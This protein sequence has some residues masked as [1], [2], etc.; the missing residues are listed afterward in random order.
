MVSY[1]QKM[2]FKEVKPMETVNKLKGILMKLGIETEEEWI[3]ESSINTYTVRITIKGTNIGANGKG[4]SKEFSLASGYAEFFERFQ[5]NMLGTSIFVKSKLESFAGYLDGKYMTAEE[6]VKE[7]SGF[8]KMYFD[9]RNMTNAAFE[10]K[11]KTFKSVQISETVL[12]GKENSYISLPFYNARSRKVE[13]LPKSAYSLYYGSNGMSAGNTPEEAMV[14]GLSEIIERYIQKR[15]FIEKPTLPDI[16]EEYV[17]K[18][19]YIY[20]M[21]MKLKDNEKYKFMLKD[22]S[23]GG[24]YPVA[25]LII[26]EKNTG[27]YGIKLGCHSDYGIAMER[28]FTEATQGQDIFE[29]TGRSTIDFFNNNVENEDNICNSYKVGLGQFPYQ[30]FGETPS[31]EFTPVKDV[32]NMTN[33]EI[34]NNWI[35]ELIDDGYDVYIRDVSYLGFP[36]FHII[37]PGMS[38]MQIANDTRFRAYNT[39]QYAAGLI[40]NV[41]KITKENTKYIIG[42]MGYFLKAMLENTM[43]IYYMHLEDVNL[44]CD[45]FYAGCLYMMSMC[46]VM[47]E[48]YLNAFKKMELVEKRA[49]LNKIDKNRLKYFTAM[50]HYFSAMYTM[51]D[52]KKAIKYMNVFF[53]SE[54]VEKL[55]ELFINPDLVIIKQ[56]P[57]REKLNALMDN[58]GYMRFEYSINKYLEVQKKKRIEQASLAKIIK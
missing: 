11:V 47:N 30:L 25:A 2:H 42:A 32:S 38:E 13:Y 46:H 20:D 58:D 55:N 3:T 27:R 56:Y 28:A 7:N 33:E 24:K 53:D 34:L 54:V 31:Y 37:I 48:D 19:P 14:Q 4:V 49:A 41:D 12:L 1:Q 18:F 43:S 26:I 52:H 35:N 51:K 17:K 44:P 5:N 8:M 23:F 6:L 57:S 16:P 9:E 45:D 36:S 40:N 15:L 22:C 39:R 21:Y 10:E 50:K 29:Y